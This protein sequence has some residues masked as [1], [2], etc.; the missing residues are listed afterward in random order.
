[1]ALPLLLALQFQQPMLGC[2][3]GGTGLAQR[4]TAVHSTNMTCGT[5]GTYYARMVRPA[6]CS[7]LGAFVPYEIWLDTLD[8]L[9]TKSIRITARYRNSSNVYKD[10]TSHWSAPWLGRRYHR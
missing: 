2:E 7:M 6:C 9:A 10:P 1:M 3:A 4:D 5:A 8:L